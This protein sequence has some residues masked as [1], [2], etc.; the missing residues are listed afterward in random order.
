MD[1]PINGLK[2]RILVAPLDWG[3]GHA[4]RCV[5]VIHSL[6]RHG[7]EPVIAAGGAP[8]Q[9]LRT[10]F[11]G[12]EF[13]SLEGYG[14]RYA[15]HRWQLAWT[16]GRQIPKILSRIQQENHR[17]RN[18]VKER[19]IDGL[20]SDNRYGLSHPSI[21]SVFL[22]H[23]LR[24]RT[25]L[26]TWADAL[27]QKLNYRY[28]NRFSECWVPDEPESPGLAG[29][30]SHPRKQPAIPVRYLGPQSRMRTSEG[31]KSSGILVLLSGPEPQRTLLESLLTAGLLTTSLA[32]TLVRGLP[33]ATETPDLGPHV[34]VFN[35]LPAAELQ[36]QM[37]KAEWVIAR[38]GYSTVMDLAAL[39]KKSILIPTPGQTEQEYLARHLMDSG[40][41]YTTR[42]PGFDLSK[43][44][45]AAQA[46]RYRPFPGASSHLDSTV[47]A[48]LGR[49]KNKE[50]GTRNV[51]GKYF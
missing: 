21:P 49:M 36:Q 1:Q 23:Q 3:L 35:H 8:G 22:T 16:M 41:A 43:A 24:I 2:L 33:G 48:W 45:S 38:S 13:L 19:R 29:T 5:P 44:L 17:L 26:G 34:Q 37:R 50:Q 42:Q 7:A 32:A 30:L 40:W 20:I 47:A 10:E 31:G 25:G 15:R 11:P 39:G 14:I 28:I 6:L 9:L 51:E 27:L 4:T 46:F 18:L 12:L